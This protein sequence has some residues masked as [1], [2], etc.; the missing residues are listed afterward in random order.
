MTVSEDAQQR[1]QFMA[2]AKKGDV[3]T[4]EQCLQRMLPAHVV[5]DAV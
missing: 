4:A 5:A 3:D 1:G 2:C